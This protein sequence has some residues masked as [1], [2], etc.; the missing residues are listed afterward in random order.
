ME[1]R[2]TIEVLCGFWLSFNRTQMQCQSLIKIETALSRLF[3]RWCLGIQIVTNHWEGV[4]LIS[5]TMSCL[6]GAAGIAKESWVIPR[7]SLLC[8]NWDFYH[9]IKLPHAWKD[10]M[11]TRAIGPGLKWPEGKSWKRK[12]NRSWIQRKESDFRGV[13]GETG[14]AHQ[15]RS[16]E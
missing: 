8:I 4:L 9:Y 14:R 7:V 5:G 12:K 15:L 3:S 1:K 10:E 6:S 13:K 2:S 11:R 16:P